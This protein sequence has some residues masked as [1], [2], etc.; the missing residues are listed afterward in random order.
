MILS[1]FCNR[2]EIGTTII[3]NVKNVA[4][5]LPV[6]ARLQSYLQVW[7]DLGAGPKVVQILRERATPSPFGSGQNLQGLPQ[8]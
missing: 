1:N 4:S 8:S 3:T 2:L 5:K 7:L 6:G